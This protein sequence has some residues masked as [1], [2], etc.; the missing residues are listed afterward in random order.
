MIYSWFTRIPSSNFARYT[1]YQ[2]I[3]S[4]NL[5]WKMA[6]EIVDFPM[7]NGEFPGRKLSTF[8]QRCAAGRSMVPL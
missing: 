7:K 4:S 3:P 5:T 8:T 2:H 1:P 6:I